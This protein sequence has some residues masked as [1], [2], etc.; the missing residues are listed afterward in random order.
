MYINRPMQALVR[1]LK[2]EIKAFRLSTIHHSSKLYRIATLKGPT[3]R[4]VPSNASWSIS[5]IDGA[6]TK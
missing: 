3:T 1:L 2:A 4:D 5:P 6:S